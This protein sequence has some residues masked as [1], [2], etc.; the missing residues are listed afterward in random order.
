LGQAQ[1]TTSELV[2]DQRLFNQ[3]AGVHA[4]FGD[5]EEYDAFDKPLFQD[6][7]NVSLYKGIKKTTTEE[8]PSIVISDRKADR[9]Q[10]SLRRATISSEWTSS[11]AITFRK[12]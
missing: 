4:G 2:Y 7:S 1:P 3:T 10:L 12:K 8:Y 9:N 5:E 6:R 11:S